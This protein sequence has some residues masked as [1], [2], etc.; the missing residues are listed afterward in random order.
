MEVEVP[1]VADTIEEE[2]AAVLSG[3]Q[4]L[5]VDPSCAEVGAWRRIAAEAMAQGV[6]VYDTGD[7]VVGKGLRVSTSG[8]PL[9]DGHEINYGGTHVRSQPPLNDTYVVLVEAAVG[10]SPALYVDGGPM[11]HR[12]PGAMVNTGDDPNAYLMYDDAA[13]RQLVIIGKY[14]WETDAHVPQ[15]DRALQPGTPIIAFYG[16]DHTFGGCLAAETEAAVVAV[17]ATAGVDVNVTTV[18]VTTAMAE[19]AAAVET[20]AEAAERTVAAFLAGG[21]PT[22]LLPP[23]A[24]PE[25]RRALHAAA[26]RRGLGHASEGAGAQRRLR[27]SLSNQSG[28]R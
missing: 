1:H 22:A 20:A 16:P 23:G 7:P 28:R 19:S 3:L 8:R 2:I 10:D 13:G 17:P 4:L 14:D 15:P 24:S 6:E 9:H 5:D 25:D 18:T 11:E 26:A 12:G 27:L 21:Q